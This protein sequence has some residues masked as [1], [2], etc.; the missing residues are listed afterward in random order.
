MSEN[1]VK[2]PF[3]PY[4]SAPAS[5]AL[6]VDVEALVRRW[7][8]GEELA[9]IGDDLLAEIGDD[10]NRADVLSE[11]A[12]GVLEN[13]L[14]RVMALT[15]DWAEER[16]PGRIATASGVVPMIRFG[17]STT[18]AVHLMIG[19]VR[20]RRLA[21]RVG[22]A[23]GHEDAVATRRLLGAMTMESWRQ[24]FGASPAEVADLLTFVADPSEHLVSEFF[25]TGAASVPCI[26]S[27]LDL[28]EGDVA[29][30]RR[31]FGE[32]TGI[33]LTRDDVIVA[34]VPTTLQVHVDAILRLGL[35]IAASL[36]RGAD[37]AWL[38]HLAA[39]RPGASKG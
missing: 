24:E 11:W 26:P 32:Q 14:P 25:D 17:V 5:R 12:A 9:E 31:A 21:N 2:A 35:P 20:S 13:H 8:D 37:N 29:V 38:L 33:H 7:V 28:V 19:G 27:E 10:D 3:K 34:E 18:S 22:N 6:D 39:L 1:P 36:E 16:L 30:Q 4:P 23:L 15:I